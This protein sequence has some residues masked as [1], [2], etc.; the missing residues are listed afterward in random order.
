MVV[1]C[2]SY[3]LY[4][5]PDTQAFVDTALTN[6][7]AFQAAT[8]T[9]AQIFGASTITLA[10]CCDAI[11]GT[12]GHP[13][14]S[15]DRAEYVDLSALIPGERV[16]TADRWATVAAMS[17]WRGQQEGLDEARYDGAWTDQVQAIQ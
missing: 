11:T 5:D 10:G 4:G 14:F 3:G 12:A 13:I 1:E 2:Y 16:R 15:I 8:D 7:L 9:H 6:L 17:R